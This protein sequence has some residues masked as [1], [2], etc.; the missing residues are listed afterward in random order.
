[1]REQ[2]RDPASPLEDE[3]IPDL[4]DGTPEQQWASDPQQ[5]AVPGDEPMAL[6]DYGTTADEQYE[7]E[8]LE[9]RLAR[10]EAEP[11]EDAG[12]TGEG[13]GPVRVVELSQG[14]APDTEAEMIAEEVGPDGGGYAPEERAVHI[15]PGEPGE[16]DLGDPDGWNR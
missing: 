6:D 15:E 4:Q 3:G 9:G 10:E 13:G 5:A 8:S 16:P 2:G 7:S 11:G 12:E 14:A 1:M